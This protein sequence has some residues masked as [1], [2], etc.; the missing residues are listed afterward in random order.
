ME[1]LGEGYVVG[2]GFPSW[3]DPCPGMKFLGDLQQ[4]YRPNRRVDN[5]LYVGGVVEAMVQVEALRLA[6][7][8]MPLEKLTPADVL[9]YGFYKIKALNT[10]EMTSTPL[11]YGPNR[12]EGVDEV[13]V[14]QAQ[15]GKIVKVGLYPARHIYSR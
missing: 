8:Q 4:K 10:G 14:D 2:G 9:K 12:V 15:K 13:R 7:Q 11:T 1:D 5:I 6:M 3:D